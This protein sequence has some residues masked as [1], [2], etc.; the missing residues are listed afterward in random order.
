[1]QD[2]SFVF[3]HVADAALASPSHRKPWLA[4]CEAT[5]FR[6]VPPHRYALW[7]SIEIVSRHKLL[8]R[9]LPRAFRNAGLFVREFVTGKKERGAFE[10]KQEHGE[11]TRLLLSHLA[12]SPVLVVSADHPV[13]KGVIRDCIVIG[14][15]GRLKR[16]RFPGAVEQRE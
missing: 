12:G 15:N 2:R 13:G 4:G 11:A 5:I 10:R 3:L 8:K 1:M 16:M 9:I 6:R 14:V 7:V